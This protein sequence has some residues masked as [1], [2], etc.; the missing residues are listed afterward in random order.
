VSHR[1]RVAFALVP[2]LFLLV[3]LSAC[4]SAK[5]QDPILRLSAAE[6]LDAG[7]KLLAGKKY[8][9]AR[10]YFAH[11]FEVEPNSAAGREALLLEAD[12]LFLQGNSTNLIQAEAKY[13]DFQNRFPTSAKADYVQYQIAGS[14]GRRIGRPD[15]DQSATTKALDAYQ[16]LLRLYPT[17][18]YAEKARTEMASVRD[19]L[20][21][22]E[23]LV[24]SFYLKY[25]LP[26]AAISRLTSLVDH[27]PD[28]G[29]RDEALYYL[30]MAYHA[31]KKADDTQATVTK[32]KQ[33]F[34]QSRWL[35]KLPRA[36]R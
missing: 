21:E 32:L 5:H 2:L 13:R 4:R 10:P 35:A 11:A 18:P 7:K 8:A 31:S 16:D 15:R 3:A 6:A 36:L 24:G 33:E 34:P 28:F 14:L 1:R 17:S 23:L 30:A 25:G 26:S 29:D 27:Y 9:A 12:S 19:R 20:A 22:H